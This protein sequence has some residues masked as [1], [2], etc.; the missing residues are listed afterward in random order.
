MRD[1]KRLRDLFTTLDV[2]AT[3]VAWLVNR[4]HKAGEIPVQALKQTLGV[5]TVTTVPNHFVAVS[6]AVNQGRPLDQLS[7]NHPVTR[8]LL[9]V[10]ERISP[11][12]KQRRENWL[13]TMF[14]N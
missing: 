3:K 6:A 13:T 9:D 8:A 4:F 14:G 2:P 11:A 5:D 12:Q 1:A 10:A 7:R